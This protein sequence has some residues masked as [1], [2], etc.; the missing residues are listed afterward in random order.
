MGSHFFDSLAES[1][2]KNCA[3]R[4]EETHDLCK[5]LFEWGQR[6]TPY[7]EVFRIENKLK[8]SIAYLIQFQNKAN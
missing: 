7:N 3:K 8:E 1:L 6:C 2:C 5:Y 4:K